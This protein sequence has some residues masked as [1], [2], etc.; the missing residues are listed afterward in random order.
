MM[1]DAMRLY[2]DKFV[3]YPFINERYGQTEFGWGGGME[4]Q[5]NSFITGPSENL[6]AHELAHQWFGDRVTCASWTD[7]WL[8]EGFATYCAD[9]LYNETYHPDQLAASVKSNLDF[10]VSATNGSVKVSDTT[11]VSRIF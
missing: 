11:S 9:I 5:T 2:N 7:I 4:H 10:I 6:M 3:P 8:N 1:L